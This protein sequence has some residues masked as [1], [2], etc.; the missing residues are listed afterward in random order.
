MNKMMLSVIGLIGGILVVVGIFLPWASA[1]AFGIT[2]SMS[3]WDGLSASVSN[4]P[5]VLL[6]LIGGILALIGG[7]VSMVL[8]KTKNI[9]YLIPLGGVL[10][11]IGWIWSAYTVTDWSFVSYGFYTCLVG[12]ILALISGIM[13]VR[14]KE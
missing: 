2:V 5:D 12:G 6:G 11:I 9:S 10:T 4:N 1:T 14:A 7:L 13:I 8:I 3:G